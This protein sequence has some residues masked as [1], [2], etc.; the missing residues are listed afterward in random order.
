MKIPS[1]KRQFQSSVCSSQEPW[2]HKE[3]FVPAAE[4]HGIG[5]GGRMPAARQKSLVW[6]PLKA[7]LVPLLTCILHKYLPSS[8]ASF[9]LSPAQ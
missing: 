5:D 7:R 6:L 9:S 4:A 8:L 2:A 3:D 1:F